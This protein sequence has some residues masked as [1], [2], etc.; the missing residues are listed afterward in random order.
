MLEDLAS[1]I[2]FVPVISG[3]LRSSH[4]QV[5][6]DFL[7][8]N[9][10]STHFELNRLFCMPPSYM[11]CTAQQWCRFRR[12]SL[13]YFNSNLPYLLKLLNFFP[14][15]AFDYVC[16]A[17]C[18]VILQATKHLLMSYVRNTLYSSDRELWSIKAEFSTIMLHLRP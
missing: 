10:L 6:W 8:L 4:S 16:F 13:M 7:V 5:R 18:V 17:L 9:Y 3:R 11:I 14:S 1:I 15:N 12:I 2:M